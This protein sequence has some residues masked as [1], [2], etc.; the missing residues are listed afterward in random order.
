MSQIF[1]AVKP[2]IAADCVLL[3]CSSRLSLSQM[4]EAVHLADRQSW[5]RFE[6]GTRQCGLAMWELALLRTGHHPFEWLEAR[7]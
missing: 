7:S 1:E 6:A 3:R 5:W 4:A 2:P